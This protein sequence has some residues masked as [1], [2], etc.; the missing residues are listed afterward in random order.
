MDE[1]HFFYSNNKKHYYKF[2]GDGLR[3]EL[4]EFVSMIHRGNYQTY[5]LSPSESTTINSIIERFINGE[6]VERM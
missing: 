2:G 5:K 4:A 1:R 6:N 3:Y